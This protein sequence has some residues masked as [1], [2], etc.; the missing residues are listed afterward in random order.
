MAAGAKHYAIRTKAQLVDVQRAH[1]RAVSALRVSCM[2]YACVCWNQM[3]GDAL[4]FVMVSVFICVSMHTKCAMWLRIWFLWRHAACLLW[5][6]SLE[7][8]S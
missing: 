5:P 3:T 7:D 4:A 2:C 8:V 6:H 1:A